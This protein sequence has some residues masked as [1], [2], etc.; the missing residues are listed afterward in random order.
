MDCTTVLGILDKLAAKQYSR[1]EFMLHPGLGDN[2]THH[3]YRHW[4]YFCEKDL[5]LLLNNDLRKGLE[6]RNIETT[7]FGKEP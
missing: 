2:H 1:V 3:K 6:M 5:A 4:R 7:F